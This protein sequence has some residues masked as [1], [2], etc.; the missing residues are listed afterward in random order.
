MVQV[1]VRVILWEAEG[2]SSI[3]VALCQSTHVCGTP[4]EE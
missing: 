1:D 4:N 3:L 2:I